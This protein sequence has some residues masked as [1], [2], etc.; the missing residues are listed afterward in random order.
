MDK[1][2]GLVFFYTDSR[3]VINKTDTLKGIGST[4]QLDIIGITETC[5]IQQASTSYLRQEQMDTPFVHR[6]REGRRWG[7]VGLYARNTLNSNVNTTIK[8][9]G[10]LNHY[11]VTL[12]QK[13]K[14]KDCCKD[15]IE[16]AR[17][18]WGK[19]VHHGYRRLKGH[20]GRPTERG[21]LPGAFHRGPASF[22]GPID[23]EEG[24]N[25]V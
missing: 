23:L 24:H 25:C 6:D 13:G 11:R 10:I 9:L 7:G 20:P 18:R 12:L 19:L 8:L 3:I 14:K 17:F 16:S 4:E 21:S 2:R 5:Q 15:Y 22:G 1:G